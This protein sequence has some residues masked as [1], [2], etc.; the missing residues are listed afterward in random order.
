MTALDEIAAE[1]RIRC[2]DVVRHRP[3]DE[4]WLVAYADYE[5]GDLA[6]AGWPEGGAKIADCDLIEARNDQRHV[7]C[8]GAW[9]GPIRS[10]RSDAVRRLYP[11]AV[12]EIERLDRAAQAAGDA[13]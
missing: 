11:E 10:R 8:V 1:R 4:E 5:T 6:W 3:S 12:A 13:P 2:G 9:I 7:E